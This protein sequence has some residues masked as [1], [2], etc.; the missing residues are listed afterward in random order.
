MM[1][2]KIGGV[3]PLNNVQNA[4]RINEQGAPKVGNDSISVSDEAKRMAAL[5]Y[6][7]KVSA[8]T[9]DVRSDRVAAV[10]EKIKDPSY[11]NNAVIDS[12]ADR[13]MTSF[14]L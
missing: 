2:D 6:M 1:I 9:P 4:H 8:E 13:I 5:Y 3:N 7:N 12:A 11:L 14:G 10:K